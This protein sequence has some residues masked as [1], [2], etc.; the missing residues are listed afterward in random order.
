VHFH[1]EADASSAHLYGNTYFLDTPIRKDLLSSYTYLTVGNRHQQL[2]WWG[3]DMHLRLD[4][5][6]HLLYFWGL[7]MDKSL[8]S[9]VRLVLN[10][11]SYYDGPL[12]PLEHVKL[13]KGFTCEPCMIFFSDAP[14]DKPT[15]STLGFDRID[16]ASLYITTSQHEP[17]PVDVVAL[18]MK[19][20]VQRGLVACQIQS[21]GAT[22]DNDLGSAV[23][24]PT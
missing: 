15:Y 19:L 23:H 13:S 3:V 10:G 16:S 1:H 21:A 14:Y 11:H 6:A 7:D 2:G 17:A 8:I 9:N 4:E 24:Q 18:T 20:F 22:H 5:P 12:E